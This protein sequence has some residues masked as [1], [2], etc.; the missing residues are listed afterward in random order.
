MPRCTYLGMLLAFE[1]V[2][3]FESKSVSPKKRKFLAG[4]ALALR[5]LRFKL[6]LVS[7]CPFT[8]TLSCKPESCQRRRSKRKLV[9]LPAPWDCSWHDDPAT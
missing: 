9:H 7:L 8:E 6:E 1:M 4:A 5:L 3:G 2:G